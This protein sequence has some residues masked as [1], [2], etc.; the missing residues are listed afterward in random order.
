M[1]PVGEIQQGLFLYFL[2]AKNGL[3]IFKVFLKKQ[4]QH[5]RYPLW[6]L[7]PKIFT[8]WT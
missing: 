6:P 2:Q 7:K 5:S 3:Y 4:G 8:F 1:Q